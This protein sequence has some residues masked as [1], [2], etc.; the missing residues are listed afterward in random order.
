L[1]RSA[2]FFRQTAFRRRHDV[3]APL[4]RSAPNERHHT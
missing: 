3:P 4:T 1:L 2:L